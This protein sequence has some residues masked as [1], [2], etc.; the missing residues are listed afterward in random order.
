[1][2]CQQQAL[3]GSRES[4][5]PGIF[6]WSKSRDFG[7]WNPGI[8]R[9]LLIEWKWTFYGPSVRSWGH[10][11]KYIAEKNQTQPMCI[12]A[13]DLRRHFKAHSGGRSNKCNQCDF[14]FIHAAN[15]R[16]HLKAHS[17]EKQNKCNRCDFTPIKADN[18]RNHLKI[19]PQHIQKR[20]LKDTFWLWWCGKCMIF[21]S[22]L[23]EHIERHI[24]E[25]SPFNNLR[26][27]TEDNDLP[28]PHHHHYENL[29]YIS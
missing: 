29:G 16:P 15:L 7:K 5:D 21:D 19:P 24:Q 18:L 2:M 26:K 1:M 12:N 4:R 11:W 17:G 20:N 6:S 8:F 10:I 27:M 25:R 22:T 28:H 14:K 13:G 3:A 23:R 9:D